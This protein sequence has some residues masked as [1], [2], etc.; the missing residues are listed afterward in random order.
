MGS[1][2][3]FL[4]ELDLLRDAVRAAA[5]AASDATDSIKTPKGTNYTYNNTPLIITSG[6]VYDS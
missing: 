6:Y 4:K 2:S 1:F 5:A 3:N